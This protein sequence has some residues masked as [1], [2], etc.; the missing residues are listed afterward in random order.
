MHSSLEA[1]HEEENFDLA[2]LRKLNPPFSWCP[3]SKLISGRCPAVSLEQDV[4]PHVGNSLVPD[5]LVRTIGKTLQ[6]ASRLYELDIPQVVRD[7][8][9]AHKR[10]FASSIASV[11]DFTPPPSPPIP[12]EARFDPD[13]DRQARGAMRGTTVEIVE[14]GRERFAYWS[15]DLLFSLCSDE[16]SGEYVVS[17]PV[18][19][20]LLTYLRAF[21]S[22]T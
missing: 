2:L 10:S 13:F 21:R 14:V 19:V 15:L 1:L 6:L 7:R 12:F 8:A 16:D 22:R 17:S 4:L 9:L 5:E 20:P 3:I 11:A 18:A